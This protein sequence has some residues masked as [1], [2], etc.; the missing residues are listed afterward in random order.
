MRNCKVVSGVILL[1]CVS[2]T[3]LGKTITIGQ[4]FTG[5][6]YGVD[7]FFIPPDT[8]GGVGQTYLVELIN[9]RYSV[10][11]KSDGV[12]VQ[13]SSLNQFWT[14]TGVSYSGFTFD[15][16]V[17]YDRFSSRWF[18]VAVDNPGASN[19]FLVAVSNSSNP[20][21][22]WTGFAIDADSD[23]QQW[24]D[25]PTLGVD[26]AGVYVA[27][28]MFPTGFGSTY[29]HVLVL[30]K[31]DLLAGTPTV[32]NAT[33]F[34][35]I[36]PNNTG[37]SIQPVVDMGNTGLPVAL[38]SAYNVP[39]GWLKRSD[40]TG[41]INSPT[42]S[43][44]GGFI[45]ITANPSPPDADQPGPK[46][47][48]ET[49]DA[50]FSSFAT[51]INGS[52]WAVDCVEDLGTGNAAIAW[53]EIRESDNALLQQG[54]IS[55]PVLDFFYPSIAVNPF[56]DVMIGFSGSDNVSTFVS[57]YAILGETLGGVTTFGSPLLLQSGVA[58]YLQLD[59]INRN[60][61]GDYS[62]TILD[63]T[64]PYTFWTF[65]EWVSGTDTWSTQI[66]E[67]Q[68][69]SVIPEPVSG[70]LA[71]LGGIALLRIRRRG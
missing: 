6:T 10:Y 23:N 46:Q 40:I 51:L 33:L 8:M 65:Q 13:T 19:N 57:T 61:W 55:D 44:G 18:A 71:L 70:M 48:I 25:F 5:S 22:G 37:Y 1:V 47:N 34:E 68:I 52:I 60:R 45:N 9:G 69:S 67:L 26:Q 14:N 31:S 16:R 42:L 35:S 62:A 17:I 28:N 21:G 15:P 54:L 20:T 4:N 12:R 30:P 56:G 7:S 38:M 24:A 50:R 36:N 27:A 66:T 58:D 63:P 11:R 53:Y 43:T 49:N 41:T 64:D 32:A 59:S 29:T 3:V 39:S 2:S